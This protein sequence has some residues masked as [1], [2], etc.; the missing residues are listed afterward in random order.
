MPNGRKVRLTA[1]QEDFL[2]GFYAY[3]FSDITQE[4]ERCT[5]GGFTGNEN[6]SEN[7]YFYAAL[8][9]FE[10][11]GK[12]RFGG[13]DA[14]QPGNAIPTHQDRANVVIYND[15]NA[16]K[17]TIFDKL[18]VLLETSPKLY[19]H[20]GLLRT[21]DKTLR[22]PQGS[23][24]V[25]G[26]LPC[27]RWS[28]T[29]PPWNPLLVVAPNSTFQIVEDIEYWDPERMHCEPLE[30]IDRLSDNCKRLFDNFIVP[31]SAY[32]FEKYASKIGGFKPWPQS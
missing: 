22:C 27:L 30:F 13:L 29:T 32:S 28:W 23:I 5:R 18:L 8:C 10:L 3:E 6:I 11:L 31:I 24:V 20:Y 14:H 17:E 16:Q 21:D 15:C 1:R 7:A 26:L 2:K 12:C 4:Y 25:E 9:L 19:E